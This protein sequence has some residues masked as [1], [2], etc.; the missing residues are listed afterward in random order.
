LKI[1]NGR[2]TL[3]ERWYLY[4]RSCLILT[5]YVGGASE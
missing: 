5:L 1:Q 4:F 3:Y 2:I